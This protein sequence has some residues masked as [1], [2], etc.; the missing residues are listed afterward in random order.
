ME[1]VYQYISGAWVPILPSTGG[2]IDMV[3]HR[4]KVPLY[5]EGMYMVME[6][7]LSKTY[8]PVVMR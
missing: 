1:C 2:S 3:N 8:I 6:N 4:L 5:G 7:T